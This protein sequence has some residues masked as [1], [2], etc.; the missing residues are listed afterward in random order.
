MT[1]QAVYHIYDNNLRITDK[2][3]TLDDIK[4]KYGSIRDLENAGLRLKEVT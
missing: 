4:A 3:M 2:P 1:K